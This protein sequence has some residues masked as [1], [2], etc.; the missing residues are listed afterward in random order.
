VDLA[1]GLSGAL[2]L[3]VVNLQGKRIDPEVLELVPRAV[4]EKY[5]CLPL[6]TKSE[7]GTRTLY[8]GVEDPTDLAV[9]DDVSFRSGLRVR[10]VVVGPIQLRAG[11]RASYP[12]PPAPDPPFAGSPAAAET[13]TSQD[14]TA[15]ILVAA[16]EAEADT[17]PAAEGTV[18]ESGR[19]KPRDVPTRIILRALLQVL[20]D[21]EVITRRELLAAV[22]D[23]RAQQHK[24]DA[25]N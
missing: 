17:R 6:F 7:Q 8:L 20:I 13:P 24:G 2:R 4:A 9:L 21:K 22:D 14:D 5:A 10:P 18:D 1:R 15:P 16:S 3:P 11:L 12:E 19:S 25:A 23:I